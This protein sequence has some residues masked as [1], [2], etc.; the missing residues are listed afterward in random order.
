M[1]E[2]RKKLL[3]VVTKSNFGGAQRYVYDLATHVPEETYEVAV[4]LGGTGAHGAQPGLLRTRLEER[5]VRTL[6]IPHFMRNMSPI[7]DLR[8]F[9]ELWQVVRREKPDILHVSSS[10]AGGMGSLVGRLAGVDTIIFTSHGLTFDETWRPWWQRTLIWLFT[11]ITILLATKT[12]QISRDTHIRAS[13]MPFA[14]KK[15]TLVH[16]GIE[17]P[18]FMSRT[19]AR[20]RLLPD[21]PDTVYDMCWIGTIAEYHPNKNLD[22]L[23]EA[24]AILKERG[25]PTHLLLIGE[26]EERKNL[27]TRARECGVQEYVHLVGYIPEAVRYLTALDIFCLPSKKEGLPYVLLEA[28]YA[29]LPVVASD[30]TGN[31]EIVTDKETGVVVEVTKD[32]LA[33]A[34]ERLITHPDQA[35]GYADALN[36]HV[37]SSFSIEHMVQET[38]RLYMGE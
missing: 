35:R 9:F 21:F 33:S 34:F 32:T 20:A 15:V 36:K 27:Q 17:P 7:D 10:K 11:W 5:G 37:A 16:N 26:G 12:I 29:T 31:T 24:L 14:R 23:I 13:R 8:A 30:I 4:A 18:R 6:L 28:G 2:K 1:S 3:F 22:V 19:E 25:M 38:A